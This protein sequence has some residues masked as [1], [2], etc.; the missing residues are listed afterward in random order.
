MCFETKKRKISSKATEDAKATIDSEVDR[1]TKI[2]ERDPTKNLEDIEFEIIVKFF[3]RDREKTAKRKE[4][5]QVVFEAALLD[6]KEL[7][8]FEVLS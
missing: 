7:M 3:D 4:V 8:I 6:G 5:L 2:I 1:L